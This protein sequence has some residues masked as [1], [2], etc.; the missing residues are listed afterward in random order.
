MRYG[1]KIK[2]YIFVDLLLRKLH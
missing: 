2:C 1:D